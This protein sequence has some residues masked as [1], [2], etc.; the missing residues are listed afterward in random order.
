MKK[1][2]ILEYTNM[3]HNYA[4]RNANWLDRVIIMRY[5]VKIMRFD[6]TCVAVEGIWL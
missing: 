3:S 5:K 4:I 6:L 2:T 1:M